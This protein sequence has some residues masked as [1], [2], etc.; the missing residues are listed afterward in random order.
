M[1][2]EI[3][4]P[5]FLLFGFE[6]QQ[7]RG[8]GFGVYFWIFFFQA[9]LFLAFTNLYAYKTSENQQGLGW[10]SSPV[11]GYLENQSIEAISLN[12]S[13]ISSTSPTNTHMQ[14]VT[15]APVS[16]W[17]YPAARLSSEPPMINILSVSISYD[18]LSLHTYTMEEPTEVSLSRKQFLLSLTQRKDF[19]VT[20]T[21][22]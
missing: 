8:T 21:V 9:L 16:S 19:Y 17:K 13:T 1:K 14:I 20:S 4:E 15:K 10:S 7:I 6:R 18:N 5:K 12:C 3:A 11:E 2:K 22:E